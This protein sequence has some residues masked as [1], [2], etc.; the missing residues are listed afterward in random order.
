MALSV[1]LLT[2]ND[3]V[4]LVTTPTPLPASPNP[5]PSARV[6]VNDPSLLRGPEYVVVCS[7]PGLIGTPQVA[8]PVA[9][10]V[11]AVSEPPTGPSPA[12]M[13]ACALFCAA[14]APWPTD[15]KKPKP[16]AGPNV[17]DVFLSS[18]ANV[19][20]PPSGPQAPVALALN[21]FG[22]SSWLAAGAAGV[23]GAA[24]ASVGAETGASG[25]DWVGAAGADS[26]GAE[27]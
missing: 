20:V 17:I 18:R 21:P 15:P 3:I 24:G 23:A 7:M 14:A 1:S 4:S 25:A 13:P 22:D 6:E 11:P 10:A 8:G 9:P 5:M 19:N 27:G 2:E 26:V 16:W 12:W